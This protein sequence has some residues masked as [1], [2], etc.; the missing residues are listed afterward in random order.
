MYRF[1]PRRP[2]RGRHLQP[3]RHLPAPRGRSLR[4]PARHAHPHRRPSDEPRGGPA[5]RPMETGRSTHRLSLLPLYHHPTP[6]PSPHFQPG[7]LDRTLTPHQRPRKDCRHA[8]QRTGTVPAGCVEGGGA[9]GCFGQPCC[10]YSTCRSSSST[11]VR[12]PSKLMVSSR[13]RSDLP[14]SAVHTGALTD[15]VGTAASFTWMASNS[16]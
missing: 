1:G 4:L 12:S 7:A 9:E 6:V 10:T 5:A 11:F 13:V 16:S 14:S 15:H 2:H 8:D 3:H